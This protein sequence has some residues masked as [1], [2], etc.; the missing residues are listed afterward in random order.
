MT[1]EFEARLGLTRLRWNNIH[2]RDLAQLCQFLVMC[3]QRALPAQGR[4][5]WIQNVKMYTMAEMKPWPQRG[6][7]TA[8]PAT[9][10]PLPRK[11]SRLS[12]QRLSQHCSRNNSNRH[13]TN[14][15]NQQHQDHHQHQRKPLRHRPDRHNRVH[16]RQL[17]R[18]RLPRQ[19]L[20]SSS[21]KNRHHHRNSSGSRERPSKFRSRPWRRR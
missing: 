20:S 10:A 6:T 4:R 1:L 3:S 19:Y 12:S 15:L 21:R 7:R 5:P 8:A 17:L 16:N 2:Y 18:K 14:R 13:L 9:R 11:P